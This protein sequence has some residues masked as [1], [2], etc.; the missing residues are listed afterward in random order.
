VGLGLR[1]LRII[2]D[3]FPEGHMP[4]TSREIEGTGA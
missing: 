4:P 2:I 3:Q 1:P